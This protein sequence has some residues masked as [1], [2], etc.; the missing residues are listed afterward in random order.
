MDKDTPVVDNMK[1]ITLALETGASQ[2]NM[3]LT[4]KA[5]ETADNRELIRA[6]AEGGG[7]TDCG[8]GCDGD[9]TC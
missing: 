9:C 7:S 1:K 5:I 2:D 3:D 6:I 8:C 4:I